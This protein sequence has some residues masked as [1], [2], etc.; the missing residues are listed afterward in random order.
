MIRCDRPDE[1]A[2]ST[3]R[4]AL[5]LQIGA[6]EQQFG[7]RPTQRLVGSVTEQFG[8][9]RIPTCDPLV[10]I[11]D[12]DRHRTE[13]DKRLEVL[14]LAT[15]LERSLVLHRDVEDEALDV[16]R[17]SVVAADDPFVVP[18]P[19]DPAVG[20][21]DP[22]IRRH[23]PVRS[24]ESGV[25]GRQDALAIL[26]VQ[27]LCEERIFEPRLA[28]ITED[29]DD[30]RADVRGRARR[31]RRRGVHGHR[32]LLDQTPVLL[33]ATPS[34]SRAAASS[35]CACFCS[36]TSIM[37]PWTNCAFPSSSRTVHDSS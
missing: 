25:A 12:D 16:Q 33:L 29:V 21:D 35:A 10:S 37:Q 14:L 26:G 4:R 28:R 1:R 31:L 15:D 2:S 34:A 6:C 19:D 22:E 8:R 17:L 23:P 27:H 7:D 36:V 32:Q 20:S 9:G 18:N 24:F 13:L 3:H 11:G 30:L 5:V